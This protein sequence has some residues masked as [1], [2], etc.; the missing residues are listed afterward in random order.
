MSDRESLRRVVTDF[1]LRIPDQWSG[2]ASDAAEIL[3]LWG[4]DV[5]YVGAD[6]RVL[7]GTVEST[8]VDRLSCLPCVQSVVTGA[9]YVVG[10]GSRPRSGL[11]GSTCGGYYCWRYAG[12]ARDH[13]CVQPRGQ[14]ASCTDARRA[15]RWCAPRRPEGADIEP[16]TQ[17]AFTPVPQRPTG[18]I[19]D[20]TSPMDRSAAPENGESPE[21]MRVIPPGVYFAYVLITGIATYLLAEATFTGIGHGWYTG[22]II[23]AFGSLCLVSLSLMGALGLC[24][25]RV[26]RHACTCLGLLLTLSPLLLRSDSPHV[27]AALGLVTML[28]AGAAAEGLSQLE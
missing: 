6:Q 24:R 20:Y 9:S 11:G 1:V 10:D 27:G 28:V 4:A 17:P 13:Y 8:Q 19:T 7:A 23:H 21:A 16:W 3:V 26:I 15:Q 5:T 12:S 18:S 14:A 25:R 22:L 2:R